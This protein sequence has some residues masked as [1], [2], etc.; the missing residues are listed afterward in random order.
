MR[1]TAWSRSW[2]PFK[3]DHLDLV[4]LCV[5]RSAVPLYP[6]TKFGTKVLVPSSISLSSERP[7][8]SSAPLKDTRSLRSKQTVSLSVAPFVSTFAAVGATRMARVIMPRRSHHQPERRVANTNVSSG[9]YH[10]ELGDGIGTFSV[11]DTTHSTCATRCEKRDIW[12]AYISSAILTTLKRLAPHSRTLHTGCNMHT[13]IS[14]H[15]ESRPLGS[16]ILVADD[17]VV[18]NLN[19]ELNG[20]YC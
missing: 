4:I 13:G 19:I 6:W 15:V 8:V 14:S 20:S 10:E 7:V 16:T 12:K 18:T 9:A 2:F 17:R 5:N 11:L 3:R 1:R